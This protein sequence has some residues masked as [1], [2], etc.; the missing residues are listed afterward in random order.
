M[1]PV[2]H[3]N[4]PVPWVR[5]DRGAPV[6][7]LAGQAS[8]TAFLAVSEAVGWGVA[9]PKTVTYGTGRLKR[10]SGRSVANSS[11][12]VTVLPPVNQQRAPLG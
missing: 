9:S 12:L 3:A 10:L 11:R 2:G 7:D 5:R 6:T 8:R 4:A 1:A